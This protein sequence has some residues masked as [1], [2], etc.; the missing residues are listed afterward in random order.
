VAA[1]DGGEGEGGADVVA[2]PNFGGR[3]LAAPGRS[4]PREKP[5]RPPGRGTW[6]DFWIEVKP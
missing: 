1:S 5:P 3:L 2:D 4:A 6:A